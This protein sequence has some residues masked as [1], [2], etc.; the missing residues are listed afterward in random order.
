MFSQA[1]SLLVPFV[2]LVIITV[3]CDKFTLFLQNIMVKIPW[4]P[5]EFGKVI[6]YVIVFFAGLVICSRGHYCLFTS[7]NF[8]FEHEYEGWILTSVVVAGG[9]AFLNESFDRMNSMPGV[10]SGMYSYMSR[11]LSN[12]GVKTTGNNKPTI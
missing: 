11:T 8:S 5:N 3:M 10:L 7:L 2:A 9:S 6:G 4:L 1:A 12:T